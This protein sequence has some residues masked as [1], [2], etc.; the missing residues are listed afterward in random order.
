MILARAARAAREVELEVRVGRADLG[1]R[2]SAAAGS[3]AR[4]RF[5]CTITPVAFSTRRRLG[6]AR[7]LQLRERPLDE[8][9][10]VAARADLL[11]RTLERRARGGQRERPRLPARRSSRSSPSTD[12][13]ARRA[14]LERSPQGLCG[15]RGAGL[16]SGRAHVRAPVTAHGIVGAAGSHGSRTLAVAVRCARRRRGSPARGIRWWR[17]R[18]PACSP[19]WRPR[20]STS[21]ASAPRRG[22]GGARCAARRTPRRSPCRPGRATASSWCGRAASFRLDAAATTA[23]SARRGPRGS[24]WAAAPAR[25]LAVRGRPPRDVAPVVRHRR[26][27]G[28]R[29]DQAAGQEPAR[30][31]LGHCAHARRRA[32]RGA[33]RGRACA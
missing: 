29:H 6:A 7:R 33:P 13:S 10:G 22:R 14:P 25:S 4:P 1:T 26:L 8:V 27:R 3:G 2:S 16:P 18:E 24:F 30:A 23:R 17:V 9:A 28:G 20:G 5:V 12:G 11:A 19:A 31:A 15:R 32:R 21:A